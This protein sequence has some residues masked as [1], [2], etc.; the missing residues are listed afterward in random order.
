MQE[1]YQPMD[2]SNG[3]KCCL[4]CDKTGI[5]APESIADP[6]NT[7]KDTSENPMYPN[8]GQND[9]VIFSYQ[10]SKHHSRKS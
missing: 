10:S 3:T 8:W 7:E 4:T 5:D 1:Y 2:A 9:W 6:R